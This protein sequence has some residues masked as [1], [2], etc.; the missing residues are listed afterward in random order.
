MCVCGGGAQVTFE[1]WYKYEIGYCYVPVSAGPVFFLFC[2]W[3][4]GILVIVG[5]SSHLRLIMW[6]YK[7][8]SVDEDRGTM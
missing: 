6:S 3:F 7:D 2:L 4:A 5:V 1:V 8:F